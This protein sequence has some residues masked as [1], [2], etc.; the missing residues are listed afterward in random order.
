GVIEDKLVGD[1]TPDS[2]DRVFATKVESALILTRLLDFEKLKCCVLFASVASRY[3]NRGQS[4]YAAANEVLAKLAW[5]LDRQTPCRVVAI[6]WG[7]WSGVGM[8]SDLEKHMVAR[9]LTLIDPPTGVQ[10][11][12]DELL[13]GR[14]GE[15]EVIIGGGAERL[16]DTPQN[17]AALV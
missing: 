2:F 15:S 11:F 8:V 13:R 16:V 9:G 12:V 10:F 3:G 4:D 1:K 14:K 5:R 6:D 7:P 17:E